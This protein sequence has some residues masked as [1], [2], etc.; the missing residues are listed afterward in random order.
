VD[1]TELFLLGMFLGTVVGW[2]NKCL[3]ERRGELEARLLEG[4]EEGEEVGESSLWRGKNDAGLAVTQSDDPLSGGHFVLGV[5][6]APPRPSRH[7]RRV[8]VHVVHALEMG[9]GE[10]VRLVV[11]SES[12]IPNGLTTV[13]GAKTRFHIR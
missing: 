8:V 11:E 12:P 10:H 3:C 7:R 2:L 5:S 1:G 9:N 13:G 6:K 4:D